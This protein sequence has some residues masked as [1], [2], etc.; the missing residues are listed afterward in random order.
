M[1]GSPVW[2]LHAG[3]SRAAAP[4]GVASSPSPPAATS[5]PRHS[6]STAGTGTGTRPWA[7]AHRARTRGRAAGRHGARTEVDEGRAAAD[8]VRDGVPGADLVEVDVVEACRA[9]VTRPRPPLEGRVR[10][11]AHRSSRSAR[12]QPVPDLRPPPVVLVGREQLD[13]DLE[14]AHARPVVSWRRRAG[15]CPG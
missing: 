9:P 1:G 12:A 11:L 15:R 7:G 6:S 2:L 14:G 13:V 4:V 5:Q 8:D 3:L 10:P